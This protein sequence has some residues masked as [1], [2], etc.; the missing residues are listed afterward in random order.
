MDMSEIRRKARDLLWIH[1]YYNKGNEPKGQATELIVNKERTKKHAEVYTPREAVDFM[2]KSALVATLKHN[3]E[4]EYL[5]AKLNEYQHT[6]PFRG[7]DFYNRLEARDFIE[8]AEL[9]TLEPCCGSGN[10]LETIIT[11]KIRFIAYA[12]RKKNYY[13]PCD[14]SFYLSCFRVASTLYGVDLQPD[15]VKISRA[16]V[17]HIIAKA[18]KRYYKRPMP[19]SIARQFA[20]M[21]RINI[22]H[23]DTLLD[24]RVYCFYMLT[25]R[26]EI[27]YIFKTFAGFA[28]GGWHS[29][30]ENDTW[31]LDSSKTHIFTKHFLQM[32]DIYQH[33]AKLQYT[34]GYEQQRVNIK[35]F[36]FTPLIDT[37]SN[38]PYRFAQGITFSSFHDDLE[39]LENKERKAK[40]REAKKAKREAIKARELAENGALPKGKVGEQLSLF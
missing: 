22:I 26:G 10:F 2:H 12:Y 15:N 29:Y 16:R 23:G 5:H 20:Y 28:L 9:T 8:L 38:N 14:P 24:R 40:E 30:T 18:C 32:R 17:F 21:L 34:Y 33:W 6:I 4:Y 19:L 35:K 39:A 37:E 11:D 3:K 31:D 27:K 13:N 1:T 36:G 7:S 25:A